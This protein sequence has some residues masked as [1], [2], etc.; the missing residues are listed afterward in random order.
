MSHLH[1]HATQV[2]NTSSFHQTDKPCYNIPKS[3]L[4]SKGT[5]LISLN[6][7]SQWY[8]FNDFYSNRNTERCLRAVF[9]LAHLSVN[10]V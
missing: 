3:D 8:N 9:S 7:V 6:P 1:F 4:F 10:Q 2:V 5:I